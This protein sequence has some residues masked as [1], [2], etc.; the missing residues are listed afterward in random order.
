MI[1]WKKITSLFR[2]NIPPSIPNEAS[3]NKIARI[4]TDIY[5][6]HHRK[7]NR[8]YDTVDGI[9]GIVVPNQLIIAHAPSNHQHPLIIIAHHAPNNPLK[10]IITEGDTTES[11]I[12]FRNDTGE[13]YLKYFA[14]MLTNI[15]Q[16]HCTPHNPIALQRITGTPYSHHHIIRDIRHITA[17]HIQAISDITNPT[18]V[19][20]DIL[21]HTISHELYGEYIERKNQEAHQD[22]YVLHTAHTRSLWIH[23]RDTNKWSPSI[24]EPIAT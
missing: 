14:P 2:P 1:S 16:H 13:E 20:I 6:Y 15:P 23:A 8:I 10:Y 11:P 3:T 5:Q 12:T 18:P 17:Q 4:A 19:S 22:Y 7:Y 21:P 24:I 9:D